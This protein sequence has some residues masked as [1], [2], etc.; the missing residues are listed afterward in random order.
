MRKSIM[1]RIDK[2]NEQEELYSKIEAERPE[3]QEDEDSSDDENKRNLTEE[4]KANL[5][6]M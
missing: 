2:V 4:E 6:N 5:K 3:D 1:R